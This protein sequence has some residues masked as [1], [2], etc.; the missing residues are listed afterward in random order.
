V[1]TREP[2]CKEDGVPYCIR[3]ANDHTCN[4][5][6]GQDSQC[7]AA[8][9]GPLNV[10][11]I[12]PCPGSAWDSCAGDGTYTKEQDMCSDGSTSGKVCAPVGFPTATC[13]W[14]DQDCPLQSGPSG[15]G[16]Q[17]GQG[18]GTK[19]T[20]PCLHGGQCEQAYGG[21]YTCLCMGSWTGKNCDVPLAAGSSQ[22]NH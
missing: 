12:N 18:Y 14:V 2:T 5:P 8:V 6:L 9:V 3:F 10:A 11:H 16:A 17:A 15:C 1:C 7:T 20:G 21:A 13:T 22:P 19:V 4:G